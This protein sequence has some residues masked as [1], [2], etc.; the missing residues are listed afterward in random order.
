[1]T[2]MTIAELI[3]KLQAIEDQNIEIMFRC[4]DCGHYKAICDMKDFGFAVSPGH[5]YASEK[6]RKP[7]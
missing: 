2:T 4:D 6:E 7:H 1:M 3:K 5:R